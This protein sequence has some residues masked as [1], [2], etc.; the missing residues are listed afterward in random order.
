M[1]RLRKIYSNMTIG[2]QGLFDVYALD[3]FDFCENLK[4]EDEQGIY[5]FT[6]FQ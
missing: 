3:N 6:D 1:K 5:M 2:K 4:F